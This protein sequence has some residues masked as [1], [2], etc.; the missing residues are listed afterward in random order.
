MKDESGVTIPKN[1]RIGNN[2]I[3]KSLPMSIPAFLTQHKNI[4]NFDE[5]EDPKP[6][7]SNLDIAASMKAIAKSL[8][9]DT[10]F[11]DLPKPRY[12]LI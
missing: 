2:T 6:V 8:H 11:G 4:R 10:V 5:E 9:G 1:Q 7:D 3:A 12:N